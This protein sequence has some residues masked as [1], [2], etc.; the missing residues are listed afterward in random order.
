[1]GKNFN[2]VK[3]ADYKQTKYV[4]FDDRCAEAY[5]WILQVQK[6][7]GWYSEQLELT[8]EDGDYIKETNCIIALFVDKSSGK[9]ILCRKWPEDNMIKF[10]QIIN[11]IETQLRAPKSYKKMVETGLELYHHEGRGY[12]AYY[13]IK[14][15][16]KQSK[17]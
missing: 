14:Q 17:K 1:M 8:F 6:T 4:S 15:K 7:N 2:V 5:S 3:L 13:L 16:E 12:R 9:A 11:P 10:N